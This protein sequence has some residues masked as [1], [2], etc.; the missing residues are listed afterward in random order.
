LDFRTYERDENCVGNVVP[1][2]ERR[3]RF[4]HLAVHKM[5]ILERALKKYA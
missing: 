1:K 2:P 4:G 5:M 3:D